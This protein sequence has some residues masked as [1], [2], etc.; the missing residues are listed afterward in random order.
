MG[1]FLN[2]KTIF[3]DHF[4]NFWPLKHIKLVRLFLWFKMTPSLSFKAYFVDP[5]TFQRQ[6]NGYQI[7]TLI[8]ATD[9][10]AL[11]IT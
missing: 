10:L 5:I 6:Q 1:E 4:Q 2:W 11:I 9:N 8:T 7:P 3:Q